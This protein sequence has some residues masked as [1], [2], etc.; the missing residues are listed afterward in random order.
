MQGGFGG[1][2][3]NE[4][5]RREKGSPGTRGEAKRLPSPQDALPAQHKAG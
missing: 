1:V 3:R 4:R 5:E 2:R